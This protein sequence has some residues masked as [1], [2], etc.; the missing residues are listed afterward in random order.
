VLSY[1][2]AM[3]KLEYI[4]R[5]PCYEN[6]SLSAETFSDKYSSAAFYE[7]VGG[8]A[9]HGQNFGFLTHISEVI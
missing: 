3:Q 2:I 5:N 4:H 9:N 6:W 1:A 7:V 8:D